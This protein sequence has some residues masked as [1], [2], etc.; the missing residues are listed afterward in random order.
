MEMTTGPGSA[1]ADDGSDVAVVHRLDAAVEALDAVDFAAWSDA[2]LQGRLDEVSRVLCRVEAQLARLA[3][4]VRERGFAI[5]EV[6]RPR[7]RRAGREHGLA[8]VDTDLPLAS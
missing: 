2:V 6:D 8:I 4:A 1:Q 3:D 7:T 5:V